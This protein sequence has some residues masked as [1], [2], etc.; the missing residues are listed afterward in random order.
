M[1]ADLSQLSCKCWIPPSLSCAAGNLHTDLLLPGWAKTCSAARRFD[2]GSREVELHQEEELH[3]WGHSNNF[4]VAP[5]R[6]TIESILEI[7]FVEDIEEDSTL[8]TI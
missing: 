2:R 3:L 7:A 8:C 1:T 5:L 6:D 4:S